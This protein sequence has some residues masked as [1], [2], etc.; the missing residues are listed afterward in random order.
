MKQFLRSYV[1]PYPWRVRVFVALVLLS[2]PYWLA[3]IAII[4]LRDN[5][6]VDDVREFTGSAIK[7]LR[8]GTVEA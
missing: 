4:A 6:F 2:L 1:E 3:V 5:D 8:T 7:A